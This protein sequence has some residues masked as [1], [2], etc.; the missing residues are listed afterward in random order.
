M[1]IVIGIAVYSFLDS[2]AFRSAVD[3]AEQS[4]NVIEQTQ[5]LIAKLTAAET[6]QRGYLLTGDPE[7]LDEYRAALPE[8]AR[9]QK[10]IGQAP[11]GVADRELL[12]RLIAAK[13]EE[14][15][16]T[17][18]VRQQGDTA[19]ALAIVHSGRGKQTMDQI[20]TVAASLIA[21]ENDRLRELA[22]ATQAHGSQTRIVTQL[23]ALFLFCLLWYATQ[24]INR[25]IDS[26]TR[27][28]AD[29]ELTRDREARGRAELSTT[30]RSIGDAV[31][32]TDA[33]RLHTLHEPDRG[34]AHRLDQQRR[35][36]PP[37]DRGLPHRRR[38][39]ARGRAGHSPP[40][41]CAKA[42]WWRSPIIPS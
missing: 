24:R 8:V 28:I 6:G 17:V 9:L 29:L 35:L 20:R 30:L 33:G 15:A 13:L 21:R 19:S 40:R 22:A 7:Y 39:L 14:L 38:T 31:I 36:R 26:Q 25:L 5:E 16:Q 3:S 41:C 1:I 34:I 23:G 11:A 2:L 27:L 12:F 42:R 32:A 10:A 18:R 4:R 37:S